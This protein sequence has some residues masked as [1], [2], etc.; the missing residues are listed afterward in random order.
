MCAEWTFLLHNNKNKRK[1]QKVTGSLG[2]IKA[3]M[4]ANNDGQQSFIETARSIFAYLTLY[5]TDKNLKHYKNPCSEFVSP[6]Q[7]ASLSITRFPIAAFPAP[8]YHKSIS[9]VIG[10]DLLSDGT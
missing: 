2:T 8:F 4:A 5:I 7:R 6:P 1:Q 10:S 3:I 9:V